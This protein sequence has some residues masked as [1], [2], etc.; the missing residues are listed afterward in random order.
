MLKEVIIKNYRSFKGIQR[1][2]L[3]E[4]P[5]VPV[6]LITSAAGSGKTTLLDS[7]FWCLYGTH[8]DD[9]GTNNENLLNIERQHEMKVGDTEEISVELL[10]VSDGKETRIFRRVGYKK[11]CDGRVQR[12]FSFDDAYVDPKFTGSYECPISPLL[13]ITDV[14]NLAKTNATRCLEKQI[15]K[16][17]LAKY[18]FLDSE[19]ITLI[20][21]R[22]FNNIAIR[23]N[24]VF[25]E[26][27]GS[28]RCYCICWNEGMFVCNSSNQIS[29]PIE[30]STSSLV[31]FNI[32]L[33][34]AARELL[35][36][37]NED[38]SEFPIIIDDVFMLHLP[39]QFSIDRLSSVLNGHQILFALHHRHILSEPFPNSCG[40]HYY[41]NRN[42]DCTKATI[43]NQKIGFDCG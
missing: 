9:C 35:F 16:Y 11:L 21:E 27:V 5:V 8:L 41:L 15:A 33:M 25:H 22:L 20:R 43:E 40:K 34:Y 3:S 38:K 37:R 36:Y 32:A 18:R 30:L 24:I 2:S 29:A 31:A 19:K 42:D 26:L 6:T 4:D 14:H 17:L 13:F 7:I 23:A 10:F 1:F 12:C 28:D 39:S